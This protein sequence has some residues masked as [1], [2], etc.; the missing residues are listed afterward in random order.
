M[1]SKR[2]RTAISSSLKWEIC[3][4]NDKFSNETY[5]NI[6]QYFNQKDSALN[7]ERSTISKILKK[8]E[9]WLAITDTS[10]TV[11]RHKKVKFPLLDKA[12]QLWVEQV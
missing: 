7:L 1:S 11:F 8:K 12:M 9:Q 5:S 2:A 6:A 10:V 3:E 4:Y